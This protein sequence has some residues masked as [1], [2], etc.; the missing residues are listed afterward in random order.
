M[1]WTIGWLIIVVCGTSAVPAVAQ[2]KWQE[3]EASLQAP[4][5]QEKVVTE[6]HFTNAGDRPVKIL[7]LEPDCGCTTAESAKKTYAPG[8]K[9]TVLVTFSVG[10]R[11]GFSHNSIVVKTDDARS[12]EVVLGL[13][14]EIIGPPAVL[15]RFLYW[16][17]GDKPS[18]KTLTIKAPPGQTV[19]IR[20]LSVEGGRFTTELKTIE[21][22]KE[23][24]VSVTPRDTGRP[25]NAV[26]DIQTDWP[27]ASPKTIKAFLR[28]IPDE[29]RSPATRP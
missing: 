23:Y 16:L 6:F 24:S 26:L 13:V 11:A 7:S 25:V 27:A 8:E 29:R 2:L 3:E 20:K 18:A 4:L 22:G 12:P 19:A 10:D 17:T 1:R 15:P 9:G 21:N 5:G 28:I 14:I